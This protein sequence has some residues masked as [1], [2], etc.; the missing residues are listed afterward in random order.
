M[1]YINCIRRDMFVFSMDIVF[2]EL[3]EDKSM[4]NI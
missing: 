3:V 1:F 4:A 2:N